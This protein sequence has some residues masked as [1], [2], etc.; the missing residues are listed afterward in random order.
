MELL[1]LKSGTHVGAKAQAKANHHRG[2]RLYAGGRLPAAGSPRISLVPRNPAL[3]ATHPQ[4]PIEFLIGIRAN[5][6]YA[7]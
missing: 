4:T 7:P 6:G 1:S 3:C 5:P 2:L